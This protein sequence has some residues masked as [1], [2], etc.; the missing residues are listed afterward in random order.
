MIGSHEDSHRLVQ[1]RC[2]RD[3][4]EVLIGDAL[5]DGKFCAGLVVSALV[6][7]QKDL[8]HVLFVSEISGRRAPLPA[9]PA[10][11]AGVELMLPEDELFSRSIVGFWTVHVSVDRLINGWMTAV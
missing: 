9:P 1:S 6:I 5:L 8:C 11:V 2:S 4:D 7:S 3:A 10:V